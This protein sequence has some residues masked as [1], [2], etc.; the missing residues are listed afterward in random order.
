MLKVIACVGQHH[1]KLAVLEVDDPSW[2]TS[3]RYHY[4]SLM[5]RSPSISVYACTRA[6]VRSKKKLNYFAL[7]WCFQQVAKKNYENLDYS[8]CFLL[9]TNG[10][11]VIFFNQVLYGETYTASYIGLRNSY[12]FWWLHEQTTKVISIIILLS[13]NL[14]FKMSIILKPYVLWIYVWLLFYA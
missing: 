9:E 4:S 10:C 8:T 12:S 11:L 3:T 13:L 5:G 7:V 14:S 2:S 1:E 6:Y